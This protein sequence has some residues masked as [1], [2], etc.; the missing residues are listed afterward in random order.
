MKGGRI[1][2]LAVPVKSLVMRALDVVLSKHYTISSKP[3]PE[4][5]TG[6]RPEHVSY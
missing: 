2:R 4:T 3:H 6:W 1:A 5:G